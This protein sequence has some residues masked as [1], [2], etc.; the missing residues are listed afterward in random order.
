MLPACVSK[1]HV[2]TNGKKAVQ[3][4]AVTKGTKGGACKE[5]GGGM[6]DIKKMLQA[7]KERR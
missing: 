6:G 4:G 2:R 1:T 5:E 3:K 7:M